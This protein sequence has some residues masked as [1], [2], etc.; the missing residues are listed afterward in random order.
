MTRSMILVALLGLVPASTAAAAERPA[1]PPLFDV[2]S[3]PPIRG[4]AARGAA[5]AAV[6]GACHGPRGIAAVT[7]FP[8]LA[9]QSATYLYVQLREFKAGQ[10]TSPVMGAQAASLDDRDMRDLSSYFAGLPAA[11]AAA[12]TADPRGR[13]LYLSGDPVAGIP[14]CQGCHGA[15]ARGPRPEPSAKPQPP[16]S[17]FPALRGQ[18]ASYLTKALGDFRSGARADSSNDQIMAGVARTL[19]DADMRALA[20][21][22]SAR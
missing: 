22:L 18:S 3:Q 20:D 5:K 19:S 13:E 17:T 14:P 16:W 8:N 6:C 4:D 11:G 9:G 7:E 1:T 21:D 10:R 12:A 15:D 2:R